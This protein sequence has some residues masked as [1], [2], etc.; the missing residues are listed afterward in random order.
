MS[1]SDRVLV[2]TSVCH[3][4]GCEYVELVLEGKYWI[5][6]KCRV[7]YGEFA[8]GDSVEK[9]VPTGTMPTPYQRE[10]VAQF[11]E[12]NAESQKQAAKIFRFGLV[13]VDN[14]VTPPKEYDNVYLMSY[15]FGQFFQVV[16]V[17][18]EHGL[19]NADAIGAGIL[20]KKKQMERYM[21][22]IPDDV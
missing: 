11:I 6:P 20:H 18:L 16:S 21:Q 7:S 3:R 22:E 19:M 12:E 5:C 2:A 14:T 1:E 17:M 10:L 9:F 15:E 8:K 13:A 4:W